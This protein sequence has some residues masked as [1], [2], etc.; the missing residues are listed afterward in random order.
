MS[1]KWLTYAEFENF[2]KKYKRFES[3]QTNDSLVVYYNFGDKNTLR[4]PLFKISTLKSGVLIKPFGYRLG[5]YLSIKDFRD[6]E[7]MANKL[8]KTPLFFRE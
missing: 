2:L 5:R 6:I 1:D 8:T 7:K 3:E 4:Q